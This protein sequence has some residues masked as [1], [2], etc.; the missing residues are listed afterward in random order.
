M[1]WEIF[2]LKRSVDMTSSRKNGLNILN[3]CK[4]QMG[5]DQLGVRY[6]EVQIL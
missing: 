5:Q 1:Y 3:K 6:A 4:S 2:K